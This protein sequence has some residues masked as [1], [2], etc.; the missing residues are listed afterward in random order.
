MAGEL[1]RLLR[2]RASAA[3]RRTR[4]CTCGCRAGRRRAC[5]AGT[6]ARRRAPPASWRSGP[7]RRRAPSRRC[8]RSPCSPRP[9]SA[10]VGRVAP[11]ARPG[12]NSRL[13]RR[14]GAARSR[15]RACCGDARTGR[16]PAR[17]RAP[18]RRPA[19]GIDSWVAV[20]A[21]AQMRRHVVGP[22]VVMLVTAAFGR[23]AARNRLRGRAARPERHSPGS[24]A[25]PRCGGRKSSADPRECRFRRRNR[26]LHR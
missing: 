11:Q 20:S 26:A 13:I 17:C 25:R 21:R 19:T 1:K 23:D 2:R 5:R 12:P 15:A 9:R 3:G 10:Q 18:A 16:C 7:A 22:F 24:G 8:R 4:P 6:G 14:P